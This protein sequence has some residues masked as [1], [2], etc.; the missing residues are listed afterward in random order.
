MS[1][2]TF[3]SF[4]RENPNLVQHVN[5]NNM[6]WQ[7][8]YEMYELYGSNNSVWDSYI[9]TEPSTS[10][11]S[12]SRIHSAEKAF[13]ELMNVVKG[14]NLE[15]VQKGI[16]SIQKTISLVQ[17]LGTGSNSNVQY[18]RRPIYKKFED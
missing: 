5:S 18:E 11:T 13:K 6:T 1:K 8:F 14:I 4:V 17:E 10:E 3:K 15:K 7:K 12:S 9:K 2:E 16:D